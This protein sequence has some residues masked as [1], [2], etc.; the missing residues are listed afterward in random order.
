MK[1]PT[2][3]NKT[4]K[5]TVNVTRKSLGSVKGGFSFRPVYT[6]RILTI[7]DPSRDK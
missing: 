3:T 7:K 1:K 5:V 2:A 4:A 6:G